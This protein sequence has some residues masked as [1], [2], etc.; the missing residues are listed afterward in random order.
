M[1]RKERMRLAVNT[2]WPTLS[3]RERIVYLLRYVAD[4][5]WT[6]REIADAIG[7]PKST[8]SDCEQRVLCEIKAAFLGQE[9]PMGR[10]PE[11]DTFDFSRLGTGS[12]SE[13]KH[14]QM[15]GCDD[16]PDHDDYSEESGP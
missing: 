3:R 15:L 11:I 2:V 1:D 12:K 6:I 16:F 10:E 14:R 13:S 7:Q 9:T 4:P 5:Q 8:V